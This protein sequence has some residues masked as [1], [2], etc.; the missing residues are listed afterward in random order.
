MG[1]TWAHPL[2]P[3]ASACGIPA[4]TLLSALDPDKAYGC[5][6]ACTVHRVPFND[7]ERAMET[8][9]DTG[10]RG[11][12]AGKT[13]IRRSN[14]RAWGFGAREGDSNLRPN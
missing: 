4:S 12:G 1:E 10:V 7:L 11:D 14:V 9:P 8:D 3:G 6:D 13:R 2:V 5:L